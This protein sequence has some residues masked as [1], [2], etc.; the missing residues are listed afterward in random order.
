MICTHITAAQRAS[1]NRLIEL[2]RKL[3]EAN[4]WIVTPVSDPVM[5]NKDRSEAQRALWNEHAN[6]LLKARSVD[7]A[8]FMD[9]C[10]RR[11]Q[12]DPLSAIERAEFERNYLEHT[13]GITLSYDIIKLNYD[14]GLVQRAATLQQLTKAWDHRIFLAILEAAEQP[15]NRLQ[16]LPPSVLLGTVLVAAGV[17][18]KAGIDRNAVV[19]HNGLTRFVA[20]CTRNKTL[21]EELLDQPLRR[22]IDKNPVRQLNAFLKLAGLKLE[23]INRKKSGGKTTRGYAFDGAKFDLMCDLAARYRDLDAAKGW[24]KNQ[25]SAA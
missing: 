18:G 7:E 24:R 4:G 22:E 2:F 10:I 11:S 17:G 1:K 5:P 14:C 25:R 9:L 19:D 13:F 3:R 21:L 8:S 16:K 15:L 23:A 12:G 6:E 20:L